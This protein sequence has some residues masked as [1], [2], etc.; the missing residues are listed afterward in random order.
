VGEDDRALGKRV[1][2]VLAV[3]SVASMGAALACGPAKPPMTP[4]NESDPQLAPELD[5][6]AAPGP[7][8]SAVSPAPPAAR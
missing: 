6:S 4:D 2:G 3:V 5:A 8:A 7:S 1:T